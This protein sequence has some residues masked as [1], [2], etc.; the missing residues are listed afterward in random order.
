MRPCLD[1]QGSATRT[2]AIARRGYDH[3]HGRFSHAISAISLG[4]RSPQRTPTVGVTTMTPGSFLSGPAG[5]SERVIGV[6]H[7]LFPWLALCLLQRRA[8]HSRGG[9]EEQ[10]DSHSSSSAKKH[11]R[12]A[13]LGKKRSLTPHS[14]GA[15]ARGRGPAAERAPTVARSGSSRREGR[16]PPPP[17]TAER[18]HSDGSNRSRAR[19]G[20]GCTPPATRPRRAEAAHQDTVSRTEPASPPGPPHQLG[21]R[22]EEKSLDS[23]CGG[24]GGG[25]AGD[26]HSCFRHLTIIHYLNFMNQKTLIPR[27]PLW[28]PEG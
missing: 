26:G 5:L 9:W 8:F 1:E 25:R 7:G 27:V 13:E 18:T 24:A 23:G 17:R 20:S 3:F 4:R 11:T 22:L 28:L 16:T 10:S 2:R 6:N 14:S 15:G 12:S 21:T 19:G